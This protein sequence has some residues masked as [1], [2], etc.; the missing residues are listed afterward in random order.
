MIRN[1]IGKKLVRYR[2]IAN[3][4]VKYGFGYFVEKAHLKIIRFPFRKK[5]TEIPAPVRLRK[6]LEELGPTFIKMGQIL[7]TRPDLV[8]IEYLIEFEKL[9][10]SA[11]PVEYEKIRGVFEDNLKCKIEDVFDYFEKEP[12]ASASVSQVHIA[13]YKGEKVAVKIQK[14][15]I[16][17]K[18]YLDIG[19]LYD[20][21]ELIERFIKDAKIYKPVKIVEEFE[22]AIR[23]EIDF[24][25]EGRNIERFRKNFSSFEDIVIPEVYKELTGNKVLTLKYID[26]VKITEIDK[27]EG[28]DRKEFVRKGTE[29]ILKQIFYDGFFHAD[30]HP[31][32][33]LITKDGKICLLD[34]GIVGRLREEEKIEIIGLLTGII[35][36]D[37]DKILRI[38]EIMGSLENE[39][40][41]RKKLKREIDEYL[42]KYRDI[43]IKE[44]NLNVLFDEIFS[45]MRKYSISIPASFSLLA[46]T[47]LT[48]EGVAS[49]IYPEYNLFEYLRPY[50]VDF[51]EKKERTK[52]IL[53]DTFRSI[54]DIYYILKELPET[55]EAS[56]KTIRKGYINVAFE[57]KGLANL[58]STLDKASNRISFSLI[59]S[60]ILISSSLIMVAGK[61]PKIWGHPAFGIIG[62]IASGI[63]GIY[64]IIGIIRSGRL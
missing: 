53:K 40:V 4:I 64:L 34:F 43:S 47:V 12:I 44:I 60:S 1:K 19:I 61:G 26:G 2:E 57:H 52:W 28:I 54:S 48:L 23:K 56:L 11:E 45:L 36:N 41:D 24:S 50:I 55:V 17:D 16:E 49:I 27:I 62:F 30:P 37:S 8:P 25:Y 13:F 38:L 42:E 51:M 7:S 59:I 3:I 9:Q 46:R 33:I 29:I 22:K 31:G 32:N 63:L 6:M 15:D 14:P 20:I 35:K 5:K 18:I 10:D 39:E 58:T 21:A